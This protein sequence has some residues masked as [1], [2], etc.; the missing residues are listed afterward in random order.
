MAAVDDELLVKALLV[1]SPAEA[2]EDY[3]H[4]E[5]DR[6]KETEAD[7]DAALYDKAVQLVLTHLEGADQGTGS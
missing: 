4:A 1:R 5:I 7:F 2:F 3:A 6:L